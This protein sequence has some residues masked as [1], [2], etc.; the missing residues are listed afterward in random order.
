MRLKNN[1]ITNIIFGVELIRVLK[2]MNIL[3]LYYY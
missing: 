2:Y 1:K 3:Y